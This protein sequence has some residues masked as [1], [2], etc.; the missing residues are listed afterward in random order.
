MSGI[1]LTFG[2]GV[3][4]P[5]NPMRPQSDR[6]AGTEISV[7]HCEDCEED[8]ENQKSV[9]T[10]N[11]VECGARL[12]VIK[13]ASPAAPEPT[14]D[15]AHREWN[16]LIDF[17]GE[18]VREMVESQMQLQAPDRS[19]D[20]T[21]LSTLGKNQVDSRGT[22]LYDVD[23]R[24]GPFRALLVPASFSALHADTNI[25]TGL[26]KGNPEY[27][28][29]DLVHPELYKDKYAIFTRG[30]VSF[31]SKAKTAMKAG[32]AGVIVVQTLDIWPF[33]MTDS[34]KELGTDVQEVSIPVLMISKGDA[35]LLNKLYT[36]D[37]KH[38]PVISVRPKVTECSIC[39]EPFQEG[40]TVMKLHCRHLYHQDCVQ[41][42]LADHNTC[43]LCRVEM[44]RGGPQA[45]KAAREDPF[46]RH[47]PYQL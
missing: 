38:N 31:A 37:S 16:H 30:K 21:F 27:G 7:L 10:R 19:I 29:G 33:T 39:Q 26:V 3:R 17:L 40:E 20:Q 24:L 35:A 1:D 34:A 41:S 23:I 22:I 47:Q 32:C 8:R 11:C 15:D 42:W 4:F 2:D 18:D 13:R 25:T 14:M 46:A 6:R 45:K 9:N 5:I 43:P 44:P 36:N 28:E 12:V